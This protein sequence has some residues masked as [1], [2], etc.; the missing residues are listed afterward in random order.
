MWPA[1]RA[2]VE[3]AAV[4][5]G[6]GPQRTRDLVLAASEVATNSLLHGGGRGVVRMWRHGESVACE[7]RDEGRIQPAPRRQAATHRHADIGLRALGSRTS[8]ADLVQ[9][10]STDV[11]T[12]VRVITHR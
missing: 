2:F 5:A 9:I 4:A 11:G 8:S 1:V 3:S 6:L 10:R 7:V 12:A